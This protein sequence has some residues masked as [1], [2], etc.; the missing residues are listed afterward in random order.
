MITKDGYLY[1]DPEELKLYMQSMVDNDLIK[2]FC[3]NDYLE[4]G[5]VKVILKDPVKWLHCKIDMSDK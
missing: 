1:P 4:T 2:S 3:V 5:N